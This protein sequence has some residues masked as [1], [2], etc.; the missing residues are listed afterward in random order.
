MLTRLRRCWTKR[1]L[2]FPTVF[3]LETSV[4]IRHQKQQ[5]LSELNND[6]LSFIV[7]YRSCQCQDQTSPKYFFPERY[8]LAEM[9][10]CVS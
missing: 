10:W 7:C 4:S 3:Y 6:F 2:C 1:E 9:I 5:T 8:S